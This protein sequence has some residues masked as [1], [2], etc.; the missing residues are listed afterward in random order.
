MGV[1]VIIFSGI[2]QENFSTMKKF[3][4]DQLGCRLRLWGISCNSRFLSTA[5]TPAF[6]HTR[7]PA[8]LDIHAASPGEAPAARQR[9]ATLITVS[10]A[11]DTSSI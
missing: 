11:P 8:I 10:P 3:S 2:G 6:W 7:P 4:P 5:T 9:L 1:K